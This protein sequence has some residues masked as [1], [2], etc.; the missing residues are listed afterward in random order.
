[1]QAT[2]YRESFFVSLVPFV[3]L[4]GN[5]FAIDEAESEELLKCLSAPIK[6]IPLQLNLKFKLMQ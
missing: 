1:M 4:G 6:I 3:L 2:I 5:S